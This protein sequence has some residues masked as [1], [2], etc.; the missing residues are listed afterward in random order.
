M[1][2]T[3][4]DLVLHYYGELDGPAEERAAAHLGECE[5]CRAGLTSLQRILAVVDA[6]PAPVLPEGFERTVWARLE[7]SLPARRGGWAAWFQLSPARLALAAAVV[8]LVAAAFFAGRVSRQDAPP[9]LAHGDL[10]ER[11]LLVDLSEHL[12]RSQTMLVELV[13]AGGDGALDMAL[14]R[15]RA[16]ELVAANRLYRQTAAA[17]GD[18]AIGDL[19][20]DL[21][22]LLVDLAASPDE[23]SPEDMDAVRGRIET[24]GLLF[25]VRVLSTAVR[26]R[27]QQHNRLRAG[28][29]S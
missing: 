5:G 19:L 24:E 28:Q 2:L 6:A 26:E 20:D 10:R 8:L 13:T 21:E 27:Q 23:L 22:R 14:E 25:K 3:E 29:S 11:I 16:E 17:T 12:E 4:D 7:P 15:E 18:N 9:A 1:H